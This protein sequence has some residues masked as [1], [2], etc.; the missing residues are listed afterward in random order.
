LI[1]GSARELTM[2]SWAAFNCWAVDCFGRGGMI[3][4]P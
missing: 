1:S 3:F 2:A 4:S